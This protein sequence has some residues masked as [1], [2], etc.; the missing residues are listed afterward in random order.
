MSKR[1]KLEEA[2]EVLRVELV[3]A[4]GHIESVAYLLRRGRADGIPPKIMK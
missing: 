3:S 2:A 1:D 4:P